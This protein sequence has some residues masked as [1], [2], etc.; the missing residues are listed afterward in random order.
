MR[1]LAA[2][3]ASTTFASVTRDYLELSKARIVLMVLITTA[4]GFLIGSFGHPDMTLLL[5][6]LVGTAFVAA[7]TNA[8]NQYVE[9]DRD[10]KMNRTRNRPLPD[11]RITPGAAFGYSVA[12][13]ALGSLYLAVTVNILTSALGL[14]TLFSYLFAYTPLKLKTTLSTIVGAVPGAIPPLMGWSAARNSLDYGGWL[15]FAIL[16]LWQLPHFLAIGWIY[17][18]DYARAGYSIL[19]VSDVDGRISGRQ[20]VI[21]S[22]ALIPI[23][24]FPSF[25]GLAGGGYL[26]GAL[27]CGLFLLAASIAF[28][29]NRTMHSARRLFIASIVYLPVVMTLLVVSAP[30]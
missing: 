22:L 11:G 1:P 26:L 9:R 5:H 20:A 13:V 14:A 27:T 29:R 28:A 24:L 21:Y 12:V 19:S 16:F 4:A 15:L 10:A 2:D 6:V 23:S 17:R 25:F 3:D 18:D 8:L 7:G 30:R